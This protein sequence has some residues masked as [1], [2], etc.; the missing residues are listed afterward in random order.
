MIYNALTIDVE[1]Y[2]MVSAFSD[3]VRFEDW[4]KFESRVEANTQRVLD[5]LSEYNI[6]ATFFV[7]GWVAERYPKLIKE[8]Q[9]RG[10]ELAC[11]GYNHRL[12]YKLS[13]DE[14]RDDTR[15]AKKIIEDITG[16][17]VIGY[18]A[19]SYSITKESLWALDILIEEGF[20]YDSSIFPIIHDRY[21]IKDFNRF[22][23]R[24]N[25]NGTCGILE[26]PL[27]T[28]RIFNS[29]IPIAGGGYFRLF[30]YMFF[31][32]GI[33]RINKI[34]KQ[35]V[36]FYIHPWEIDPEQPEQN[37]GWKTRIRHYTNLHKTEDRLKR[38]LTDFKWGR[39]SDV[40]REI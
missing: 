5:L 10:H 6:K 40:I 20:K 33:Q 9:S 14:F 7:L 8:L 18:R 39:V 29:N 38:L 37:V 3:I 1:D 23:V 28:I 27:S 30:P 19:T 2:Y 4:S 34:E 13:Y 36:I 25:L 12:V 31:K 22:P 26:V 15:K 11:H 35:P 17:S 21:G 32:K 24:V 16:E